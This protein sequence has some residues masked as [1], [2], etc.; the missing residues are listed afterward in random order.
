VLSLFPVSYNSKIIVVIV[1]IQRRMKNRG[2]TT[3]M[4]SVTTLEFD[5]A[6]DEY[7]VSM[8]QKSWTSRKLE[9]A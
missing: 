4:P 2:K 5:M 6:K 3:N 9:V 7:Q 8:R 1:E